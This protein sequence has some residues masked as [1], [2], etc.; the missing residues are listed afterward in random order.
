MSRNLP[1]PL[2]CF[3][4]ILISPFCYTNLCLHFLPK[5]KKIRNCKKSATPEKKPL[6]LAII[7]YEAG[8][9]GLRYVFTRRL[10][11]LRMRPEGDRK[12]F[13]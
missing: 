12:G 11:A 3:V 10:S 8:R 6:L 1:F 7:G 13:V 5:E 2:I 9:I 4:A